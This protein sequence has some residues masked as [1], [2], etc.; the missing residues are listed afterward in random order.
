MFLVIINLLIVISFI[1]C[2]IVVF[3]FSCFIG[4]VGMVFV[5][6]YGL[7]D[8]VDLKGKGLVELR[9]GLLVVD[10][11]DDVINVEGVWFVSMCVDLFWYKRM[12]V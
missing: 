1:F 12:G 4:I 9:R 10:D 6:W 5:V 3:V 11:E 2:G 8:F 7:E